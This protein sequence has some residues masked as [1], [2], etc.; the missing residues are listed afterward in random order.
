MVT[1]RTTAIIDKNLGNQL[2][3]VR[4]ARKT[5][6]KSQSQDKQLYFQKSNLKQNVFQQVVENIPGA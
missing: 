6:F 4:S 2:E 5:L 1:T 3:A